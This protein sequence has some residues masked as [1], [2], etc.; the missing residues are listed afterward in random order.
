MKVSI[1][2]DA[3]VTWKETEGIDIGSEIFECVSFNHLWLDPEEYITQDGKY[4]FNFP[5]DRR[6]HDRV[7][8]HTYIKGETLIRLISTYR[9]KDIKG[10]NHK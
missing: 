6:K 4:H 1:S 2:T 5:I 7:E 3:G 9:N 8:V 10:T